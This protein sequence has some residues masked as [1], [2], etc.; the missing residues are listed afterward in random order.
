MNEWMGGWVD[1]WMDFWM[2]VGQRII[3]AYPWKYLTNNQPIPDSKELVRHYI[4]QNK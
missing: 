4:T 2:D 3:T 1:G